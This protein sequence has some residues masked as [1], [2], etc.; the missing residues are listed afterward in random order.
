M[1][2]VIALPSMAKAR[3]SAAPAAAGAS[4]AS[5]PPDRGV[6]VRGAGAD[7]ADV[8]PEDGG[9]QQADIGQ[10]RI[11]PADAGV[12]VEEWDALWLEEVA[13]AVPGALPAR[14][15][16]AEEELAGAGAQARPVEA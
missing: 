16:Q 8:E 14:L 7:R 1:S 2:T 9:R 6:G 11:A 13:K 12:V 3:L 10:D 5:P 4:P 15:G